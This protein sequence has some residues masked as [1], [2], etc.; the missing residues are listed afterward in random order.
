MGIGYKELLVLLVLLAVPVV[1]IVGIV[2]LVR[3]AGSRSA[4]HGGPRR[5]DDRLAELESLRH[6]GRISTE[7]YEKQRAS[8]ISSV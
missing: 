3:W 5:V 8:I 6:S 7:E 1:L 4:P 2:W